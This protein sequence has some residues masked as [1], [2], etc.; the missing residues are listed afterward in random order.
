MKNQKSRVG[1]IITIGVLILAILS[2]LALV[3]VEYRERQQ[4]TAEMACLAKNI[5]HEALREPVQGQQAVAFVTVARSLHGTGYP[6]TICGVV[7]QGTQFSWTLDPRKKMKTDLLVPPAIE[8]IAREFVQLRANTAKLK[9]AGEALGLSLDTH[10]YKRF[11]WNEHDVKEK[12]MSAPNKWFWAQC[13]EPVRTADQKIVQH[14]AHV[15]YRKKAGPCPRFPA[16]K[17]LPK[18]QP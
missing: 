17:V 9:K 2:L 15:F 5:Y 10:F 18:K 7:F 14:G 16:K 6:K 3:W 8:S 11:D 13:L 12:R 4:R 1:S